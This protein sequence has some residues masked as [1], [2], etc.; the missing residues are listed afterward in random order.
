MPWAGILLEPGGFLTHYV[1]NHGK[2]A[3][4]R[5]FG[6]LIAKVWRRVA[7]GVAPVATADAISPRAR[8]V[9]DRSGCSEFV[10]SDGNERVSLTR[11]RS[12]RLHVTSPPATLM[13]RVVTLRANASSCVTSMMAPG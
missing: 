12:S 11:A 9:I 3:R 13:L 5:Q 7:S 6:A 2:S 8:V 1:S 4:A 10:L